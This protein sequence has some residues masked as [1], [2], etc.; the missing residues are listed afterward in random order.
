[1][2]A[3]DLR[4]VVLDGALMA[5]DTCRFGIKDVDGY[6]MCRLSPGH[7]GAHEV[8]GCLYSGGKPAPDAPMSRSMQK[9]LAIQRG[10]SMPTFGKGKP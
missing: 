2:D 7:P 8:K 3:R 10:D 6:F 4:P 9:R 5:M 1:M